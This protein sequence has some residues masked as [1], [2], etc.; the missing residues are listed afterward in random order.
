[1]KWGDG[2]GFR[3]FK[4]ECPWGSRSAYHNRAACFPDHLSSNGYTG[5]I[6]MPTRPMLDSRSWGCDIYIALEVEDPKKWEA[7]D[8]E[9]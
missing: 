5:L 6:Q 8:C 1:M 2:E 9:W 4:K 3:W 7:G